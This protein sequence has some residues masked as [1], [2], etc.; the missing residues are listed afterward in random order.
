MNPEL[1]FA[2]MD[3]AEVHAREPEAAVDALSALLLDHRACATRAE[4]LRALERQAGPERTSR[5]PEL[6]EEEVQTT[7]SLITELG[8]G[9]ALRTARVD[10]ARLD[11]MTR[12]PET[13]MRLHGA[14]AAAPK[15]H[16]PAA[17]SKS[18]PVFAKNDLVAHPKF[19]TGRV[20]ISDGA[21]TIVRFET[22]VEEC[23]TSDLT[24]LSSPDA[25]LVQGDAA[26]A[27]EVIARMQA[28]A[29]RSVSES[30]G[31]LSRS[32]IDLLPH[33]LWVCKKV[34]ERWPTRWLVADDV[35]LGKTI[36]AGLILMPLLASQRVKRLLI[37]CPAGLV[38]QWSQRLRDLFD[39]RTQVYSPDS[40]REGRDYWGPPAL[41][42]V[43][44]LQ[45]L[46]LNSDEP[47]DKSLARGRW[48]R[49]L[50]GEPWDLVLVDEAHHLNSDEADAA[51]HGYR[52][53]KK[54]QDASRIRS[55]VF[56]TG[57]PHR[58]K[59]YNFLALLNLLRP[60]LFNPE[61][62]MR[63]QLANLPTAVIR[64]NKQTV[65]D[66]EG[67]P[68]FLPPVVRSERYRYS[69]QE[70]RFYALLTEFITSGKAYASHLADRERRAVI[71]VL[72]ALQKLASSSVAAIRAALRGRLSRIRQQREEL[73]RAK[74]GPPPSLD[75]YAQALASEEEDA[76]NALAERVDEMAVRL[77]LMA[78]EEARLAELLAAADA[79]KRETKIDR[80]LSLI[81]GP[82]ADRQ[83]L[84]FT[85]Y[86]ATQAAV[87][88]ALAERH[89]S[90]CAAFI[91][92]DN[93]LPDWTDGGRQKPT[94]WTLP[95]AEAADKFNA[96]TTRFLVSTEAGGEGIDLQERCHSLIHV[97]LPWNP[98][99]L[100]QRVGR[101]NRYGQTKA[102]EVYSL[103]NEDTVESLIWHHL[104][105]KLEQITRALGQ[106]MDDP[107]DMK[108]L[109]LGMASPA[110]FQTLFADAPRDKGSVKGWFDSRTAT[111]GGQD[112][113]R[114]VRD[115]IGHCE[116]F[117]FGKA[118]PQV[119]R[120]DL[121]DLAPFLVTMLELNKRRVTKAAEG[122]TFKTPEAWEDEP[123]V[124]AN[125]ERM[126]FDR[127]AAGRDA[128]R[129]LGVGHKVI[130][131]AVG[132]ARAFRGRLAFVPAAQL[133]APLFVF[134]LSDRATGTSTTL[135]GCVAGVEDR[136]GGPA[137]LRDWE[138]LQRLNGLN[139]GRS[140]Q[141]GAAPGE[142]GAARLAAVESFIRNAIPSLE[143]PYH[144]PQADLVGVLWPVGN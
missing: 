15:A 139:V 68:L 82:F 66:L 99:R 69:R 94:L 43:A 64:N 44:S 117:D 83:V 87:L 133:P 80:I 36:E 6:P 108:Q 128:Q 144:V 54:M 73:D 118:A 32:R 93:A 34:L 110:L 137:M 127:R 126:T 62:P 21:T 23:L 31:V 89:G 38:D 40:D 91:N 45:T 111:L 30:W 143:L 103:R 88:E 95:R 84:L 136:P 53:L 131:L 55:L 47:D 107:E 112:M 104:E 49:L 19:G 22:D 71:L 1:P 135:R 7:I 142:A 109:V 75:E 28:E 11:A 10:V 65:T 70:D 13:L 18:G 85:E 138:L 100:H 27:A 114:A 79:V 132:Q 25:T 29:I 56:F 9:E 2:F 98:M 17:E 42:V 78:D 76:A 81:E 14:V 113:I 33:Q 41:Q 24:L 101:I 92:G 124:R 3:F 61:R 72:I 121:P 52:L 46:R 60:E 141:G 106:V 26:P 37:I 67:R 105:D 140:P 51:T 129:V 115:L 16:G 12:D 122:L 63:E 20:R 120:V 5:L 4:F 35:G 90:G 57:T 48:A 58:G 74:K 119:P 116:R 96:G 8:V 102:V 130:D 39:I 125:Y 123:G 50:G 77:R 134:R 86:K 59:D 97:D